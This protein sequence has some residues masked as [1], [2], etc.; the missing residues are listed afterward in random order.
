MEGKWCY[1]SDWY[2][3]I[4]AAVLVHS[5]IQLG[6]FRLNFFLTIIFAWL[7]WE[8]FGTISWLSSLD[9]RII[10]SATDY[11]KHKTI[12]VRTF[13]RSGWN[14]KLFIGFI[15]WG[16]FI[17][18]ITSRIRGGSHP[19]V[20]FLSCLYWHVWVK[21]RSFLVTFSCWV[22]KIINFQLR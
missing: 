9:R 2:I 16:F 1:T 11:K 3:T 21:K 13:P 6:I 12:L 4:V 8:R 19:A 10:T 20:L 14:F 22:E 15:R 5:L 7:G 17:Y 18:L